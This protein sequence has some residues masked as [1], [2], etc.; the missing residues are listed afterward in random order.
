VSAESYDHRRITWL[1]QRVEAL[2]ASVER[3]SSAVILLGVA[4][5][6]NVLVQVFT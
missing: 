1:E 6:V 5:I 3:V 2:E 4:L